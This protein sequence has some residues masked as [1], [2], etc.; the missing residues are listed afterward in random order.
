MTALPRRPRDRR[1]RCANDRRATCASTRPARRACSASTSTA[2][3]PGGIGYWQAEHDGVPAFEAGWSV[4]PQ[5]QG[6]GVAKEALRQLIRRVADDGRRGLLVAYPGGR[7]RRRRTRCAAAPGSSCAARRRSRG[8]A[9]SSR[10][11]SG[12]STCRRSTSPA[13]SPTSTSASTGRRSTSGAGGR[14]TRRTGPRARRPPRGGA[15]AT[16]GL[17][18]LIDDDT[19]PWAP[20]L[21]GD[22]RVSHLQTGQ[23]SGPGRQ[24]RRSAPLPR[25]ASSCARSSPSNAAWLVA[26]RRDR[27]AAG[28]DPPPRRRWSR[29]GRSASRTSPD[30]CGELCIA[31]IFGSELDDDGGWVGVGRQAAERP[32]AARGL[33]EDPRRRRSHR[34][35]TTTPSSGRPS[36]CDSSSTGAG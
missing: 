36:A 16:G 1:S 17:E 28:R 7:Q 11:T 35:S 20:E 18:L 34:R 24:R 33:R 6:R 12:C 19:A 8:A 4:E 15:S 29:S 3:R 22:I 23:F 26:P 21:D 13:A 9:A 27:G 25:R 10:S 5:W 31:E 32:A 2:R 14:S 30:D